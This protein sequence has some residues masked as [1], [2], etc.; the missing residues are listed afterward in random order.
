MECPRCGSK[1][2]ELLG[3]LGQGANERALLG[4]KACRETF[5]RPSSEVLGTFETLQRLTV[6]KAAHATRRF[7]AAGA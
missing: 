2:L 3:L 6:L 1:A 4:C 7:V 5:L